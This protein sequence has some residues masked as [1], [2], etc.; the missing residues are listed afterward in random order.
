MMAAR[1]KDVGSRR[2][3]FSDSLLTESVGWDVGRSRSGRKKPCDFLLALSL[4][5]LT[6]GDASCH[7][8]SALKQP[9]GEPLR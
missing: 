8:I 7:V 1:V 4:G 2:A 6:L 9:R 3:G 5:S